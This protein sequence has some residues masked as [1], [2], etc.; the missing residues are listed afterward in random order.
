MSFFVN[1]VELK[2]ATFNQQ[3]VKSIYFNTHLI[4]KAISW[5]AAG[6]PLRDWTWEEIIN[7]CNSGEDVRQYF[8]I[9]DTRSLVLTTGE[10]V[11]VAIGDFYHNTIT[12]TTNTAAIAFTFVDCLNTQYAINTSATSQGGWNGCN[13][14]KTHMPNILATFPAELTANNAIKYVDVVASAGLNS[15]TLITSSDRLRL[16]SVTELG[17]SEGYKDNYVVEGTPYPYYK[18][19]SSIKKYTNGNPVDYWTRTP[20]IVSFTSAGYNK[21][22]CH[23]MYVHN[24]IGGT[25]TNYEYG[26]ACAFDI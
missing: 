25:L 9:G 5:P 16:H 23:Y 8:S 20:A 4:W 2:E 22:F 17:D 18:S 3:E 26:V 15:T 7:L 24:M 1:N 12:G 13:M 6:T 11:P 10:V 21:C 19:L 14:R